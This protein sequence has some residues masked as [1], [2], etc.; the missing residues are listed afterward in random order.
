M[1]NLASIT[2]F[3]SLVVSTDGR[4]IRHPT[5]K[6]TGTRADS[7]ATDD[8]A[9]HTA[10]ADQQ[11]RAL[12]QSCINGATPANAWH[13]NYAAGWT[14]GYC[15]FTKDCNSPSFA[16]ELAC[17][18]GAY[19]GQTSG[20]CL[21]RLPNPPTTSPTEAGGLNV[22]Y[23]LY[24]A[25]GGWAAGHCINDRPL[26]EGRPT[27][28]T[29][30]ACCRGAYSGQ[31]SGTCLSKLPSPPTTSP[32]SSSFLS[33]LWYPDYDTPWTDAG[34]SNKLPFPFTTGGRPT[35]ATQLACC[36]GAYAGQI[37]GKCLSQLPSPPTTSPTT[38][39]GLGAL[40]YPE[41]EKSWA[42]AGCS[43]KLPL[44]FT[45]GGRPTFP[46]QLACCKA[47][48]AGQMSG[49]CLS[50]LPS[51]PTTSPTTT[52]GGLW[53]PD[54][55]T[56]WA[57][58]GCTNA[59]PYPFSTGGRVTYD[60]QL[61][62]CKGAYA[63]QMSGKC[64]SQLPSPPTTSPTTAEGGLWY[65]EYETAWAEA[66][67]TNARPYPFG[68]GG[69]PTFETQL[70]CCKSAYA[71][72][73]SGK[74]LSQLPSPPTTS[75]TSS[76][77]ADFWYPDYEAMSYSEAGCKNSLPLPFAPGGRLTYDTQ[78]ACCKGAY[79]DQSSG[80]CLS[81]LPSPPTTSPTESGGLDV[82]YPS[83]VSNVAAGTCINNR[84][85]PANRPSF[86]TKELCCSSQYGWQTSKACM[87]DAVGIC[88][89]CE[90]HT[91]T[92]AQRVATLAGCPALTCT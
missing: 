34:C 22:Y 39:D 19:S 85:L 56:P 63:G 84:P 11:D 30:L 4:N 38:L 25:A 13:P 92:E 69:R 72:Q 18:K 80:K 75:P 36:K 49:K 58:A 62:C 73:M 64:L 48:Y 83:Q 81:Q 10:R 61:S 37:S 3:S 6:A 67:C 57:E 42:E 52:E 35:F 70:A 45:T 74:C 77:G 28:A 68:P 31:L 78:L 2:L 12:Q 60:T 33:E 89:A 55:E 87:C 23:P 53:Y 15:R 51:P 1:K 54:Y 46:T 71:G 5:E 9:V 91:G 40:W 24:E 90:C 14:H 32:T 86:P 65:P 50:Q 43:N 82:F 41:Y 76:G 20:H 8:T 17:C 16:T 79:P 21:S 26:P 7:A 47:A 29:M 88:Y 27:Y 59:R 44:P 66:G